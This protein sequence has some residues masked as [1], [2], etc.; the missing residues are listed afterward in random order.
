MFWLFWKVYLCNKFHPLVAYIPR[1][2]KTCDKTLIWG[3]G[4]QYL[5]T[6]TEFEID[7]KS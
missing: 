1:F 6:V 7:E 4:D 2:G 5:L 3:E